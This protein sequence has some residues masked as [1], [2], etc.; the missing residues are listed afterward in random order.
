MIF[1]ICNDENLEYYYMFSTIDIN[2]EDLQQNNFLQENWK[3]LIKSGLIWKLKGN[4]L[5]LGYSTAIKRK[6]ENNNIYTKKYY[7]V[8]QHEIGM[9]YLDSKTLSE[10]NPML[11]YND[12][13]EI[14]SLEEYILDQNTHL[15]YPIKNGIFLYRIDINSGRYNIN[16]INSLDENNLL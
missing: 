10:Y 12:Y 2:S 11:D 13:P 16:K 4:K 7:P 6:E 8:W 14:G 5:Y 9:K 1:D 15:Y 3:I